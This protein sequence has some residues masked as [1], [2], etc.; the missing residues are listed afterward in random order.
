MLQALPVLY[1]FRRCPYAMRARMALHY[2]KVDVEH[3][4]ILL[5]NKPA[6]ML[7]ASPKGTVP[8]VVLANGTVIEES[9]DVMLWALQQHDPQHWYYGLPATRQASI[10]HWIDANDTDFKPWLDK[11][12]YS[13]GYPQHPETYY[14]QQCETFLGKLDRQLQQS[15]YLLGD[16]ESLAD[17]AIFPFVRQCAFVNKAWFDATPYPHLQR[18]LDG[19][20]NSERFQTIMVKHPLWQQNP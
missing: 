9:R 14:R 4:E 5:K 13:V 3:R 18:W 15:A 8:V 11:Y 10:D 6:A 17:N 19:F 16:D 12:K 2:S 7:A 1:S 20:L